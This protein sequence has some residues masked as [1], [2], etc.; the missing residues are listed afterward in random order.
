MGP[1]MEGRGQVRAG[2]EPARRRGR[3][4]LRARSYCPGGRGRGGQLWVQVSNTQ[5][6]AK[7]LL[8]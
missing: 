2:Q 7:Y 4:Q 8:L 6:A 1:Q 3:G 5:I